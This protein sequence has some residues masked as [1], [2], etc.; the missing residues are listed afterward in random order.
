MGS[1]AGAA[2][3][4]AQ[5]PADTPA[6]Q[7]K[8]D[9]NFKLYLASA[10]EYE[11]RLGDDEK[12]KPLELSRAPILKWSNPAASDIQGSVFI[13]TSED[14]PLAVGSFYR[15]FTP[16][17]RMEHEFHSFAEGPLNAKFHGKPV[18]KTSDPGLKFAEI[19]N[20]GAPAANDAQRLLQ[21]KQLAK[22]FTG[23]G[24]YRK[25]TNETELRLLPHPIHSYSVPKQG[26][27]SGG[28]FAF[29]RGTDP[30][31]F[32]LIEARGKDMAGARWQYAAARMSNLAELELRHLNKPVW[33]TELLPWRDIFN[34]HEFAYTAFAFNEIPDFLKDAVE[35]PKP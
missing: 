23:S 28:L 16:T 34:R 14:R 31:I 11:F 12:E 33:K 27:F 5:K 10:G 26:I 24:K 8:I 20:A 25:D 15:W 2:I 18:W 1:F 22:D 30:E 17:T 35:K 21:L 32:L 9:A 7:E 4:R 3:G 19:P 6:N 13:W 29:V